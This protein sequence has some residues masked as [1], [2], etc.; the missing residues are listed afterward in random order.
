MCLVQRPLFTGT[1]KKKYTLRI[2]SISKLIK[3]S[4]IVRYAKDYSHKLSNKIWNKKIYIYLVPER[5]VQLDNQLPKQSNWPYLLKWP[6]DINNWHSDCKWSISSR[7][8]IKKILQLFKEEFIQIFKIS[9][10][11]LRI[12]CL[13]P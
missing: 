12:Y 2:Y 11:I 6:N 10:I 3:L 13:L 5:T 8:I 4:S 7:V 9:S 1:T